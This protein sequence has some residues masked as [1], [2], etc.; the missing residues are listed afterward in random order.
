MNWTNLLPGIYDGMFIAR[1]IVKDSCILSKIT[2]KMWHGKK[3][4][5]LVRESDATKF[6]VFFY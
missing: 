4:D 2:I 3:T 5:Q 6:S 1:Q